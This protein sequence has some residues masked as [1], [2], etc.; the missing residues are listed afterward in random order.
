MKCS[1]TQKLIS[2]YIDG[3]LAASK[4]QEF[5]DHMKVCE[6]CRIEMEELQGLR[7]LFVTA[8]SFDAPYGFHTRVMASVNASKTAWHPGISL[9]VRLAETA[10]VLVLIAVGIVSGTF[11]VKALTPDKVGNEIAS[12]HLEIFQSTPPDTLGGAYLAMTE[13]RNEK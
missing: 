6:K 8:E 1:K 5:E 10:M 13:E 12:L 3:E 11:M 9:P 4:K 7:Q 2:P